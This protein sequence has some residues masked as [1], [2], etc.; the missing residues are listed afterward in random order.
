MLTQVR[1]NINHIQYV[2]LQ[3]MWTADMPEVLEAAQRAGGDAD[4]SSQQVPDVIAQVNTT[5]KQSAVLFAVW[6]LD[7]AVWT[8]RPYSDL[9]LSHC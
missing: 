3:H 4:D 7:L 1:I 6:A 2:T 5:P 9:P 8:F